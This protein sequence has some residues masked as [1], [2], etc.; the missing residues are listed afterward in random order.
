[1][2]NTEP[3]LILSSTERHEPNLDR[4]KME[5]LRPDGKKQSKQT[6]KTK[7]KGKEK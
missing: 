6:E 1:M 4:P 3:M 5:A 2:D 7:V